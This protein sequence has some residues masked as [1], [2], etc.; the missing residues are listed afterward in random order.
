MGIV[1]GALLI[2]FA[3]VLPGGVI[4]G[5]QRLVR[6]FVRVIR[7]PAEGW[8][9]FQLEP[10]ADGLSAPSSESTSP[11]HPSALPDRH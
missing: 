2:A 5:L 8:K 6:P 10:L 7:P 9:Q 11:L 4:E 3:F 1:S